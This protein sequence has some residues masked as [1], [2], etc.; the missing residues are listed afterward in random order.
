[1]P[2]QEVTPAFPRAEEKGSLARGLTDSVA[3]LGEIH[4]FLFTAALPF[5]SPPY[6]LG[7]SLPRG[8]RWEA[9]F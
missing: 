5:H 8:V 7:S 6:A 3:S 2:P 4:R 9:E 1:V